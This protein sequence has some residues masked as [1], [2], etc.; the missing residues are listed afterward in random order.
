MVK[1][2]NYKEILFK[3][4]E[5][6][7]DFECR[8]EK[9]NIEKGD[10]TTQ[11][12]IHRSS[13]YCLRLV[14]RVNPFESHM[15]QYTTNTDDENVALHFIRTATDLVYEIRNKYAEDRPMI[16]TE[17]EQES[18]DNATTCWICK[19]DLTNDD[20]D[21]DHCHFT[22]KYCGGAH[23]KCN[24]ALKKDKTIPVGF[25]NETKYDFH[26]LVRE[27]GRVQGHIRTIARNFEQYISVEKAVRIRE[28][29]VVDKNGKPVVKKDTWYIR[30]VDTLG[31]LQASLGNCVKVFQGM[32]LKC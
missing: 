2:E 31:F 5:I 28:T 27:L 21:Q 15:I 13:G 11:T 16:I 12:Q 18:F 14:S 29:T 8:L 17:E 32:N 10:K 3:P 20:K 26:L 23:G 7:A 19:V 9:V 4:F 22:G 6:S 30:L 25:H 24:R 1:F